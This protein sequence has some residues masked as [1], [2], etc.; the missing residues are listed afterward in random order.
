MFQKHQ[1]TSSLPRNLI[2]R[3]LFVLLST[4]LRVV[5]SVCR[6]L[7]SIA[8]NFV[9]IAIAVF[10]LF[11]ILP[12]V[13]TLLGYS[14][15][16]TLTDTVVEEQL[17]AISEFATYE[18]TYTNHVECRNAAELLGHEVWLT[19]HYFA[20]DYTGTIKA[21]YDFSEIVIAEIDD[22]EQMIHIHLPKVAI[23]SNEISIDME[24]YTDTNNIN[25]P[26]VPREVLEY[27]YGR[28]APEA[29]LAIQ[30]GL[31]TLAEENAMRLIRVVLDPFGYEVVFF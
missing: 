19:D 7:L 21:G 14:H 26:L 20:F 31:Y 28:K 1:S 8:G 12:D 3:V 29:D 30:A 6:F 22:L 9:A 5:G 4:L 10:V 27:L 17:I 23:L 11:S 2:L 25:N 13:R 18:Y 24:T 15:A 16:T